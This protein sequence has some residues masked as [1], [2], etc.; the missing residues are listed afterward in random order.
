MNEYTEQAQKFLRTNDVRLKIKL[1]DVQQP[2]SWAKD[3]V[4]G[5]KYDVTMTTSRGAYTF[6]FWDSVHN[7]QTGKKPTAYD[8]LACLDIYEGSLDDFVTDFGYE[9]GKISDVLNTYNAVIDQSLQLQHILP[10]KA[11][12]ELQEIN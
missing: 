10:A 2:A 11:L 4:S 1:S 5:L 3:G 12:R 7:R 6:P 9:D 8:V